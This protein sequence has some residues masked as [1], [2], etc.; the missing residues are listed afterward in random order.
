MSAE[1]GMAEHMST[2]TFDRERQAAREIA[3]EA[4]HVVAGWYDRGAKVEW[5]GEDDPVTEADRD[6]NELILDRLSARFPG[7]S[8][9]SEESHDDLSRLESDRLWVVDPLDGTK[10]FVNRTGDFAVMIGLV[11][12]GEP[13]VG[14]VCA[15]LGMRLWHGEVGQ[16]ALLETDAGVPRALKVTETRDTS[17]MRLVVTRSHRY[18]QIDEVCR[19]LGISEE[20]PLGSVG[21]KVGAIA[22]GDADLY[23]HISI[24]TKEWDTAA[25]TAILAAAGGVVTDA[26]GV[27][28]AYNQR[29]VMR[30][31][32]VVASN[33][34]VHD[35]IIALLAPIARDAGL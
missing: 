32:G 17:A 5:K 14:A 22:A 25:P 10:D 2:A 15:P 1:P 7:D 6:A 4:A 18:P 23:A 12:G 26:Y 19:V 34:V 21:L 35:E 11:T 9:L 29:D 16:G 8:I 20:R 33:G 28:L 24:G 27:P 3:L 31:R 13:R 30:R